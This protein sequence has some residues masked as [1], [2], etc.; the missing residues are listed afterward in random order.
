VKIFFFGDVIG[1]PGR[2]GL[3]KILPVLKTRH[4]PDFIIVN[5]EN[6]AHGK[7]L[8]PKIAK[9]FWDAGMDV[10]TMGNHTFDRKEISEI[11]N[12]PRVLRPA[13]YPPGVA[14]HGHGV[15]KSRS[16]VPVAVVQLLG[17]IYMQLS[18]CPFQTI[19]RLLP[20]L[21]R[22][23]PVIFVDMHA[24]I[25]AEKGAMGWHL[26]GQVSA[27]VGTHTHV[28]TADERL[29]LQGTAFMTDAGPC[30]PRNSIIGG[31]IKN[32]TQ[33]FLTGLHVPLGVAGG[34]AQ[35]CGCVIDVDENTGKARSIERIREIVS[36]PD[37]PAEK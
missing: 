27:V 25:S 29:L 30:G 15:Y 34:D 18:D 14:G 5:A 31:D 33:R 35:V 37:I 32:A 21:R 17:R 11:I 6:A 9:E 36:L 8:T 13:N 28:Q 7:G 22:E 3:L 10:L 16:G 1:R 24:E 20:D 4:Q 2:E 26:D 19:N 12:D 23:T